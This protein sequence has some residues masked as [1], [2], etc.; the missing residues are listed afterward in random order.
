VFSFQ[1]FG[2]QTVGTKKPEPN[3]RISVIWAFGP[4]CLKSE[5]WDFSHSGFWSQ[6]SEI[7]TFLCGFQTAWVLL[8]CLKSE[9]ICSVWNKSVQISDRFDTEQKLE[10]NRRELS[11]IRTCSDF[12]CLLVNVRN[13]NVRISVNAKNRTIA[14]SVKRS[15][16]FE[17]S[18]L[19][20]SVQFSNVRISDSWDQKA[21]TERL[22][23]SHLGFWSQLSE[24]RTLGFQ[25]FGLLVPT[26]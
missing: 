23:F 22:D 15:S 24:I 7:R 4:N 12:R 3:V 5:R 21:R 9:Q 10:P 18:G 2:F 16:D 26:V 1:T 14:C 19:S 11:K 8:K 25:S 6:L 20:Y 17:C 13:P